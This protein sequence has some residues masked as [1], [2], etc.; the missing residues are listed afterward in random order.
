MDGWMGSLTPGAFIGVRRL[1]TAR[2]TQ[3]SVSITVS[4]MEILTLGDCVSNLDLSCL[5]LFQDSG[6]RLA[7]CKLHKQEEILQVITKR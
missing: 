1:C 2:K 3:I 4:L 7:F 6:L 5:N